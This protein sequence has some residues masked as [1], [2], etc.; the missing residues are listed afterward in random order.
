MS[1][2]RPGAANQSET[3]VSPPA[4]TAEEA[5]TRPVWALL[6]HK[7]GDNH[8]VLA[9]AESLGVDFETRH[10]RYRPTELASNLLLGPNLHGL[11]AASRAA[12][13]PPWPALV[14]TAGRRNE[15]V[16]R[17]IRSRAGPAVRLVHIGRPWADPAHYDLIVTTPQY[18]LGGRDNVLEVALPLRRNAAASGNDASVAAWETRLAGLPRPWIAVLVGGTS[19]MY[20]LDAAKAARLAAAAERLAIE[21]GGSLLITTSPRTPE[22]AAASIRANLGV[23]HHFFEWRPD[24]SDNPYA[25]FLALADRLIVTG[26]SASMLAEACAT[27]RPVYIFDMDDRGASGPLAGLRAVRNALRYR[28][29]THRLAQRFA[30]R[31]MRRDVGRMHAALIGAGRAV[32]LGETFPDR[33]PPPVPG[34]DEVTRRVRGLLAADDAVDA[35][36]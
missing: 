17:W 4:A 5:A 31:R 18:E 19:G 28:A 16:A 1:P 32:W 14:I 34:F 22:A 20:Q 29:W 12:L 2:A 25:A 6:G 33:E 15:P 27:R 36:P 9:L 10:L 13:R 8:Q 26:E 21:L 30:P 24:A 35:T 11:R 3:M 23:P 7:A